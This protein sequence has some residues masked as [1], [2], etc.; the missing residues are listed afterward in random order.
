MQQFKNTI[1]GEIEEFIQTGKMQNA[2]ELSSATRQH[3]NHNK[4]PMYFT[5]DPEAELV[6]VHLNQKQA[7][8]HEDF[9]KSAHQSFESYWEHHRYFGKS[10]YGQTSPGTHRSPFDNKQI[11]FLR[12]FDVI[13]FEEDSDRKARIRNLERVIDCKLQ[14]ELI[15]YGSDNFTKKCF[16]PTVLEEH[17]QR[18]LGL[19]TRHPRKYVIFCGRI[20]DT[21]LSG[22]SRDFQFHLEKNDGSKTKG[23]LAFSV[24]SLDFGGEERKVGIAHS[25]AMQG[26]T[27]QL[28][29]RYGMRCRE[30]YDEAVE[31]V[32]F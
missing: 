4:D 10:V 3:F 11:E 17:R 27:G 6:L 16:N 19:I 23:Q 13:P 2:V 24:K 7:N 20:F 21:L 29:R 5:G 26:L 18:I 15:P 12:S 8:S 30:C 32:S 9:G 31:S 28:M 14:L 25:F 22:R 1:R